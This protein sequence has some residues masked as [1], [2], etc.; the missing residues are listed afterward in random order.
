MVHRATWSAIVVCLLGFPDGARADDGTCTKLEAAIVT[1]PTDIATMLELGRCNERLGKLAR[2]MFW[3][4]RA[5]S[6]AIEGQVKDSEQIAAEHVLEI[7]NKVPIV[8]LDIQ[9]TTEAAIQIDGMDI[10]PSTF[11]KIE[12]DPGDHELVGRAEGKRAARVKFHVNAGDRQTLRLDLVEP[13][14]PVY[15]DPGRGRRRTG[16]IFGGVGVALLAGTSVYAFKRR[17]DYFDSS[18]GSQ[19]EREIKNEVR[20]LGTTGLLLWVG[21]LTTGIILYVTAPGRVEV[22]DGTALTPI[23]GDDELGLSLSGRF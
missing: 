4:R 15:A 2:A 12:L 10:S 16:L 13:A 23:I 6:T 7:A 22:S 19:E 5:Q 17:S 3:Y 21:A 9:G 1:A 20:L 14:V 8:S 18:P 11:T